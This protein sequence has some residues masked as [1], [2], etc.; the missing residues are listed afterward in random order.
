MDLRSTYEKK[1]IENQIQKYTK[2][3]LR[4][5]ALAYK[6]FT[7][8]EFN[9]LKLD[10]SYA[11]LKSSEAKKVVFGQGLTLLAVF[12]MSDQLRPKARHAVHLA[13]R[14]NINVR[15]VSGD[16]LETAKFFAKQAG[17][18]PKSKLEKFNKVVNEEDEPQAVFDENDDNDEQNIDF[19]A[20]VLCL[21]AD[22]FKERV[23]FVNEEGEFQIDQDRFAD[24]VID[25]K[26]KVIA[27]A[28]P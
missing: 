4:A 10:P 26:L 12:A 11:N 2:R 27:R 23:G 17:I 18:I 22:E 14:G 7:V 21:N 5:L 8:E 13:T 20:Q 24:V 9:S 3:G 25:Q 16:N 28:T 6:D 1:G 15:L 19:S